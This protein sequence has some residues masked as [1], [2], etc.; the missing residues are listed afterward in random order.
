M[1]Q[2]LKLIFL[3]VISINFGLAEATDNQNS[4]TQFE[5]DGKVGIK[6]SKG[7]W[8]FKPQFDKIVEDG[9]CGSLV[10]GSGVFLVVYGGKKGIVNT[11]GKWVIR[12][13]DEILHG[14]ENCI[15][16]INGWIKVS[17]SQ[18]RYFSSWESVHR[19]SA[20]GN[21]PIPFLSARM[22]SG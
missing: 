16:D 10:Y 9:Y 5:V 8:L 3:V 18:C 6:N 20:N 21:A 4:F 12:E 13:Y 19:A 2:L 22:R 11:K 15:V 1:Q 17:L 14:L 7:E